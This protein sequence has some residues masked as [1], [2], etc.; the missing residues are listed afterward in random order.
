MRVVERYPSRNAAVMDGLRLL[1]KLAPR[2][3][4]EANPEILPTPILAQFDML[5]ER[6]SLLFDKLNYLQA[7][8]YSPQLI[9]SVFDNSADSISDDLADEIRAQFLANNQ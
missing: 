4:I 7:Q 8:G 3:E 5:N 9:N 2:V 1:A 6:I